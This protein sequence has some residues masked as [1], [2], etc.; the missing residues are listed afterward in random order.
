M[1]QMFVTGAALS[2]SFVQNDKK[3]PVK[4]GD[5][6]YYTFC[7]CGVSI[8]DMVLMGTLAENGKGV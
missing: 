7:L 4:I 1:K 8:I 2:A 6:A 3:R 5:N